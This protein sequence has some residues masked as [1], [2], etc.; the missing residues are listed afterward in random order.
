[1]GAT[2]LR[3]LC[4][5]L[6][7]RRRWAGPVTFWT[8]LYHALLPSRTRGI[9][10]VTRHLARRGDCVLDV[11]ANI[12][13]ITHELARAVG[14]AGR[15]HAFE[16]VPMARRVLEALVRL[17]RLRQVTVVAA[18]AGSVDGELELLVPL[19]DGWKP[20]HQITHSACGREEG[21]LSLRVPC[22]RLDSYWREQG[23][24][25]VSLLKCDTEGG[26]L[27]V[28]EGAR[29][30]LARCRPALFCE[31]EEPYLARQ[32]HRP[33]QVFAFLGERGYRAFRADV[34]ERLVEVAG[35]E[36]RRCY[37]FIHPARWPA[38]LPPPPGPG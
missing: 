28:L 13:R 21:G 32:G 17:R 34:D 35:Y 18:A 14:P 3:S 36:D 16:P 15:V 5:A 23:E 24:P 33:E 19:K 2:P 20:M 12:G 37:F 38:G 26:E 22:R 1:M 4:I 6:L 30:L 27:H 10:I 8:E 7:G 9:G 31:V 25:E 11:G 29:E